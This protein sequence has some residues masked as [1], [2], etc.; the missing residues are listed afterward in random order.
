MGVLHEKLVV[1]LPFFAK[2]RGGLARVKKS[3]SEKNEVVKKGG[4]GAHFYWLK[5][6][7]ITPPLSGVNCIYVDIR[8]LSMRCDHWPCEWYE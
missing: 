5:V 4:G 3:L 6:K 7:K 1:F 8:S 2:K